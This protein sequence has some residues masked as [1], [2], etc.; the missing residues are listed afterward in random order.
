MLS[1][2]PVTLRQTKLSKSFEI[3]SGFTF[4]FHLFNYAAS[5][6]WTRWSALDL[7]VSKG[8]LVMRGGVGELNT[9]GFSAVVSIVVEMV[10]DD[11]DNGGGSDRCL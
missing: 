10:G 8:Y 3:A 4:K 7:A 9:V 11:H 5:S 2:R 6:I 1:T